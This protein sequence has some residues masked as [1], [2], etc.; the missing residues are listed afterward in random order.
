[1]KK[2][3]T[4]FLT[5]MFV[6]VGLV[7]ATHTSD[8]T[9]SP[10]SWL[11]PDTVATLDFT[12]TNTGGTDIIYAKVAKPTTGFGDITCGDAPADWT[13]ILSDATYCKYAADSS[14]HYITA[15]SSNIFTVQATPSATYGIKTWTIT[16]TDMG[17]AIVAKSVDSITQTIQSAI[18]DATAGGTIE[19]P[20]GTY[21]EDLTINKAIILQGNGEVTIDGEHTIIASDVT[22]DGFTFLVDANEVGITIDSSS[23]PIDNTVITNN[24]FTMTSSPVVGVYIGGGTPANA[25]TDTVM[26]D[27]I[28]NG[29]DNKVCNPWKIGGDFIGGSIS[30]EVDGVTFDGNTVNKCSIPINLQDE[31]ISDILLNDNTFRD[32]DGVVYVWA[33]DNPTGELSDFVFTNNDVDSSNTYGVGIDNDG[34]GFAGPKFDDDNFGSGN[35][36]NYNKFVGIIGDYGF[37]SVSILASL[38]TYKLNAENNWWGTATPD[39]ETLVLGNVDYEPYCWDEG[40]SADGIGPII[41]FENTPYNYELEDEEQTTISIRISDSSGVAS[42]EINWDGMTFD[43]EEFVDGEEPTS[44]DLTGGDAPTHTYVEAG[45]YTIAVTATDIYGNEITETVDVSVYEEPDWVVELQ[46]GWNLISIPLE[47]E[48]SDIDVIFSKIYDNIVYDGTSVYTVYQYNAV[49]EEWLKTRRYDEDSAYYGQFTGSWNIVPGYAYWI[50]M[51]N[52]D[53]IYGYEK[54]F[55]GPGMPVPSVTLATGKWNLVGKYGKVN[56]DIIDKD[57]GNEEVAFELLE[58]NVFLNNILKLV[59]NVWAPVQDNTLEAT[60]GYWIRTK[61]LDQDTIAYEPGSYYFDTPD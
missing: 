51:E 8:V 41:T 23:D 42:Y 17:D 56:T 16:T 7:S 30:V 32:T 13:L 5:V 37:K 38:T 11:K 27:N 31:D 22:L 39:F 14:E 21:T 47:A 19:I 58:G 28:F 46:E 33:E 61:I 26:N 55:D 25:V 54:E 9:V 20:A 2:I 40:C 18:N 29:P 44:V 6:M 3:L 53:V 57:N 12:V 48:D 34:T 24:E 36:I 1:M 43:R 50:K 49:N 60:K 4:I 10:S 35:T 15:G 45:E 52:P 59:S